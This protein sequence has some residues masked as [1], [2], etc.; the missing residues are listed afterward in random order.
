MQNLTRRNQDRRGDKRNPEILDFAL[1]PL[2]SSLVAIVGLVLLLIGLFIN[3]ASGVTVPVGVGLL[4]IGLG[5]LVPILLDRSTGRRL[6]RIQGNIAEGLSLLDQA[7]S[8]TGAAI[9]NLRELS[10]QF[11]VLRERIAR[12]R[13][14]SSE[15]ARATQRSI[16]EA[17]SDLERSVRSA[18]RRTRAVI[19]ELIDEIGRQIDTLQEAQLAAIGR[20]VSGSTADL[21]K[22]IE[23]AVKTLR[24]SQ[25]KTMLIANRDNKGAVLSRTWFP[26]VRL[27][28][29][30]LSNA[31]LDA[32]RWEN[33]E[34]NGIQ[35]TSAWI[36]GARLSG[37]FSLCS[38]NDAHMYETG[39]YRTTIRGNISECTFD[40]ADLRDVDFVGDPS[41]GDSISKSTLSWAD[42]R[43]ASFEGLRLDRVCFYGSTLEPPRTAATSVLRIAGPCDFRRTRLTNITITVDDSVSV[44]DISVLFD[45]AILTG[46]VFDARIPESWSFQDS[47]ADPETRWQQGPGFDPRERGVGVGTWRVRRRRLRAMTPR[48]ARTPYRSCPDHARAELEAGTPD[49]KLPDA[50]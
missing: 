33:C 20:E 5:A 17:V 6:K 9:D 4:G 30:D 2:P 40:G 28:N 10:A 31:W 50:L 26:S 44:G 35:F 43:G 41:S 21:A 13:A 45:Q 3:R 18:R 15:E 11:D 29:S 32:V 19:D 42:L 8:D 47:V 48:P 25:L 39:G 14:I 49:S 37:S 27:S 46:V 24:D 1:G 23:E 22:T 38:F 34:L 36:R 12:A 16:E 7:R